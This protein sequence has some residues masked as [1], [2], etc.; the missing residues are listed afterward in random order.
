MEITKSEQSVLRLKNLYFSDFS[1][2]NTGNHRDPQEAGQKPVMKFSATV[3][4][5]TDSTFTVCLKISIEEDSF[6]TLCCS[7]VGL[8][9]VDG[10]LTEGNTHWQNNAVAIM[11]PYL[12]SQVTLLTSQPGMSPIII[13][14]LNINKL[15]Q[16]EK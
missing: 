14:A 8:F 13:P 4:P 7:L 6:Y 1:F 16:Q 12:R 11:F 10:G 9:E 5:D 2:Q 3:S 15:L